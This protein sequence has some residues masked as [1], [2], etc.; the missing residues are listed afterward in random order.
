MSTPKRSSTFYTSKWF[1][2][3]SLML[4]AFI[5]RSYHL[6]QLPLMNDELSALYRLQVDS[7][8]SLIKQGVIPDGHPALVQVLLFY[9]VKLFGDNAWILKLPFIVAGVASIGVAYYYFSKLINL[10]T[11]FLVALFMIPSQFFIMHSQTAR[12]YSMGL[13]LVLIGGLLWEFC[14]TQFT[15]KKFAA[16][17]FV[18]VLIASTHYLAILTFIILVLTS[19]VL[20]KQQWKLA[21]MLAGFSILL[22]SPQLYIFIAQW[23]VGGVGTWLGKPTPSFILHFSEYATNFSPMVLCILLMGAVL[24]LVSIIQRKTTKH[25]VFVGLVFVLTFGITYLYAVLRNPVLQYPALLFALPFALACCLS[26]FDR[27]KTPTL[28]VLALLLF[29]FQTYALVFTRK[30]YTLFY[31]Q[32]YQASSATIVNSTQSG[33]PLF[34]N[35]NQQFYFDYYI[36]PT[37]YQPNYINTRIDSLSLEQFARLLQSTKADTIVVGHAFDLHPNYFEVA[38]LYFP[39]VLAHTMGLFHETYLLGKRTMKFDTLRFTETNEEFAHR[40]ELQI[41]QEAYEPLRFSTRVYGLDSTAQLIVKVLDEQGN[42]IAESATCYSSKESN[43]SLTVLPLQGV[44]KKRKVQV[45]AFV[46]NPQKR[47]QMCSQ[48]RLTYTVGNKWLY[49]TVEKVTD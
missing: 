32:G 2:A 26:G 33:T 15:R 30:H 5:F 29:S 28:V 20:Q 12:P 45:F 39:E 40:S 46:Y 1:I 44:S 11:G 8:T 9:Y 34:L 7:L 19:C 6:T 21:F 23:K 41:E 10:Q 24:T 37:S 17:V 35:G 31:N 48:V 18:T 27:F 49:G 4:L 42:T 22:Y 43:V 3:G 16:L 38:K 47:V 14:V 36:H 13:L 25:V